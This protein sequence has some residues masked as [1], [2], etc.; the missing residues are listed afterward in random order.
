M[1]LKVHLEK[2]CIKYGNR[3]KSAIPCFLKIDSSP[4]TKKKSVTGYCF[5]EF[6]V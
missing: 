5:K 6:E 1:L 4:K 3:N 2:T